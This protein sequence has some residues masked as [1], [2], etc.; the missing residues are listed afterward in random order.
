MRRTMVW[1]SL[2][3]VYK[4]YGDYSK[5]LYEVYELYWN[6]HMR[7]F[8]EYEENGYGHNLD[9]PIISY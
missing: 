4:V 5:A 9:L 3:V 2:E 6:I 7:S 1:R 8:E